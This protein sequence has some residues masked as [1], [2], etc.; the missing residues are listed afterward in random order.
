MAYHLYLMLL[1]TPV[2]LQAAHVQPPCSRT[3]L[4]FHSQP[5]GRMAECS[6]RQPACPGRL[7]AWHR[8]GFSFRQE[9]HSCACIRADEAFSDAHRE[10]PDSLS[11]LKRL[12]M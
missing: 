1:G 6:H 10:E 8:R 12:E 2:A 5:P 9:M 4:C 3:S 7:P 11:E